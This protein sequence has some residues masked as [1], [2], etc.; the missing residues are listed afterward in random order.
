VNTFSTLDIDETWT[1]DAPFNM[2]GPCSAESPEQ[3]FRTAEGIHGRFDRVIFRAG[4]WKPRTRP[5]S[6]EGVGTEG[7]LWLREVRDRFGFRVMTEVASARHVELCLEH[8]IDMVWI[9]ARSAV[10]PFSVQEIAEALRGAD[11]PVFLKNP[12][13][14][15]LSLWIG[16]L[17]RL[18]KAGI[19]KL[20][21]IHRGFHE[22]NSQPYR[23]APRWELPI[24]LKR[25]F[26]RLPVICDVSHIGGTPSL[27]PILAQK[28]IDLDFDGLMVETHAC[29][30]EAL[31]DSEQQI[32]PAELEELIHGLVI[33]RTSFDPEDGL[34]KLRKEIDDLDDLA[35]ATIARRMIVVHEI[36]RFKSEHNVTILQVNRLRTMLKRNVRNGKALGLDEDFVKQMLSLVHSESIRQQNEIMN[37]KP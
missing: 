15:D 29:P 27:L 31:S 18:N 11:L 19:R 13:H 25:R 36:G 33:R 16:G 22:W 8:G 30:G 24:E 7:L 37:K 26:D 9:G 20:G 35:L 1:E 12:I 23:N 6:F 34:E 32:T 4:I 10:N 5:G 17:E 3:M 28:A 14:S 2:Y 21:A